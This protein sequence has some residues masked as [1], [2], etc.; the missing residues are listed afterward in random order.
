MQP[1]A[2]T[3]YVRYRLLRARSE[4][5]LK[6]KAIVNYRSIHAET[7]AG[8]WEMSIEPVQ[9]GLK[10]TAFKQAVPFY[11]LNDGAEA[12]PEHTWHRGYSLGQEAYRGLAEEEDHLL[13]GRFEILLSPGDSS[14]LVLSL[15]ETPELDGTAAY[16]L[17]QTHEAALLDQAANLAG[18]NPEVRS[19]VLAADA[20]IVRRKLPDEPEGQTVIAGYPWF[21]DWGRDTMI[22]LPGLTLSTGRPDIA[23]RILE[24]YA[25][26][27]SKGMLP[28][29]FPE[30]G[31]AP[32]YNTVDAALWY[33]EAVR[34]YLQ[35]TGDKNL[36]RSLYPTLSEIIAHYLQGTRFGIRVD[37]ADGLLFAGEP[38]QQ[39]TWM[40]A[41]VG[42][43]VVTPRI[44]KPVE[45]NALWYNALRSMET[46]AVLQE[47]D[48]GPF[49]TAA[50]RVKQ[51][52]ERFW[53]PDAGFCFDVL[54]T[55]EGHD[56]RLRPN[57]IFAVSLP[58]SPLTADRRK[59][60]VDACAAAL[61]TSHG[62]RSLAVDEH[63]Y[64][65][66][67]GGPP[68]ER[69]GAYHQGTV[70]GW[71]L[72][73]FIRAHLRVYGDKDLAR[74]Y[75]RPMLANLKA[76]GLGTLSEIFDGDPPFTP[77][78]AFA[79]AWTVGEALQAWELTRS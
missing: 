40:D 42:E 52:F 4:V 59:A 5:R 53:N 2:H 30:D 18:D 22:A 56:P 45:V 78:G 60:V 24:T 12:V 44:G 32:E 73:P 69:D 15:D 79:Q 46:F 57:Q 34:S 41:K 20:F 17:R 50:D 66:R 25:R 37:P 75:L 49:R 8:G 71:L 70:W 33:F 16:R 76:H 51:G 26:Y 68:W 23:R 1:D 36:I 21:T 39:L 10:V 31:Q 35:A 38:G 65:G 29:R 48:P 27:V 7:R 72:G 61:L 67:Y 54:D 6:I 43:W 3:T 63:D 64:T 13:A 55:P 19:L 58:F 62:L 11:L 14:T 28:N 9:H 47:L 77:R 74:S